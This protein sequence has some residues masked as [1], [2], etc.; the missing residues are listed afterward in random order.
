[1]Q[2]LAEADAGQELILGVQEFYSD[3]VV[4]DPHHFLL[5]CGRQDLLVSP[6]AGPSGQSGVEY[7]IVDRSGGAA[8]RLHRL[9]VCYP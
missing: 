5:P 9:L 7:E 2:D 3:F 1:M 6:Q 8:A 4:V